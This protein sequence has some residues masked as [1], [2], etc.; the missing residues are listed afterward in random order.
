MGTLG[1]SVFGL[2]T[3]DPIKQNRVIGK[4]S[5]DEQKVTNR[6]EATSWSDVP[7]LV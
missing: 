4:T 3:Y 2:L 6:L 7:K 5:K 1:G